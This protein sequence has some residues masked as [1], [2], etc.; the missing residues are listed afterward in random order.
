ML[1]VAMCHWDQ[2]EGEGYLEWEESALAEAGS[3]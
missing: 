2:K 3:A 1:V